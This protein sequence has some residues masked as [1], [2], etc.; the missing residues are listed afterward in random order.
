MNMLK[1]IRV[2]IRLPFVVALALVALIVFAITALTTLSTVKVGGP[3]EQAITEQNILLADI[4]P[5]PAYLV[6][7]N[8]AA[9]QMRVA[10]LEGDTAT[11][12]ASKEMIE[13]GIEQFTQRQEYWQ[14]TLAG[15]PLDKMKTV[16]STGTTYLDTLQNQL[17]PA[18]QAND[19]E[20][21]A[22]AGTTLD[23]QFIEHRDA[24]NAAA[25]VITIEANKI[26]DDAKALAAGRQSMLW[27]LLIATVIIVGGGRGGR[28][29]VG[30]QAARR[31]A[32]QH[33]RDRLWR[34]FGHRARLDADRHDE[35][36]QVAASFNTFA[37]KLVAY[38]DEVADQR[39]GRARPARSR[40][41]RPRRWL[42]RT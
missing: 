21:I 32:L 4:L 5:P 8:L 31:V 11:V 24:V 22:A 17:L 35:F 26:T 2:A 12:Q 3:K 28:D 39:T 19:R 16:Q 37:D 7:T 20:A 13:V 25:A 14:R 29:H 9:L 33:G 6:E 15:A 40:S 23:A 41:R 36:G 42:R 18:V 27:I 10:A 38:A 34:R 30:A 1:N